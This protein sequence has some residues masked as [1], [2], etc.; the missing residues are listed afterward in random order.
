MPPPTLQSPAW[1]KDRRYLHFD[2][3]I[4][5]KLAEKV[6]SNPVEVA[7]HGFYPF[8]EFT[9]STPKLKRDKKTGRLVK[10]TKTRNVAYAS[11]VD[12]HIYSYYA[13]VLSKRYEEKLLQVGLNDNILAFRPL[14]KSNIHFARTAFDEIANR[15]S[16]HVLG[17]DIEGFFNNIDH[18]ILKAAWANLLDTASL[19]PDHFAVFK[20]ITK[21]AKIALGEVYSLLGISKNNPRLGRR[22]LCTPSEFR[23]IVRPAEII[24]SNKLGFGIPQGSPISALLS[25]IYLLEFDITVKSYI[26]NIKGSYF[27]YCDDILLIVPLHAKMATLGF[28]D[29]LI[30]EFGLAIQHKKTEQRDFLRQPTKFGTRLLTNKPLQYL[31]FLFDGER[32]FLRSSALARYSDRMRRGIS[33]AKKTMRKRN[34]SRV[35]R[36][37]EPQ[38]LYKSNLHKKYTH[39]G[40]RNFISYARRAANHLDSDDI[41][42]QLKP[43]WGRFKLRINK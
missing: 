34:S 13:A 27:R 25:N 40:R 19:S 33:L 43:L 6:A 12:S 10:S 35:Q 37:D 29:K 22:R 31:G 14:Q 21:Y 18:N 36:G 20:S 11:H 38:Q 28:I 9:I 1:Y 26:D 5:Y 42:R 30:K 23:E 17:L 39:F 41:R 7:K 3:P 4:G 16:C 15:E 32:I 24:E 8:I 2:E